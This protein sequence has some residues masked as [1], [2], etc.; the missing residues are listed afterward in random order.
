MTRLKELDDYF[1]IHTDKRNN[2]TSEWKIKKDENGVYLIAEVGR[3]DGRSGITYTAYALTTMAQNFQIARYAGF[4]FW[5]RRTQTG[6]DNAGRDRA[7]FSLGHLE[8]AFPLERQSRPAA[9]AK[10]PV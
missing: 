7:V 6:R 1:G 10:E 2:M 4:D 5:H 9:D 8:A 3:N